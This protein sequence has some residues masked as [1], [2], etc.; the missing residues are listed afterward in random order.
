MEIID[1][2]VSLK[3]LFHAFPQHTQKTLKAHPFCQR[4]RKTL[5]KKKKKN[6]SSDFRVSHLS[7]YLTHDRCLHYNALVHRHLDAF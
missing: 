7:L 3:E 5:F 4:S 6:E 2:I 1:E